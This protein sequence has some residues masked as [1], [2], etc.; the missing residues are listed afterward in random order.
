MQSTAVAFSPSISLSA[1]S[2]K[3]SSLYRF[4]PISLTPSKQLCFKNVR[5]SGSNLAHTSSSRKVGSVIC[6]LRPNGWI[7]NPA[8][9]N[10]VTESEGVMARAASVP[11]SA[12]AAE[13]PKSKSVLD[14]LVLGS[15]FGL[16]YLFNIY[17]NIYN[18]QV[19]AFLFF[20]L[21]SR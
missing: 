13:S 17:F 15:L 2:Q 3:A 19:L 10:Q 11:E 14:T 1:K 8:P 7:S 21:W 4:N 5:V 16:W 18:K 6:S 20:G 9:G 12:G